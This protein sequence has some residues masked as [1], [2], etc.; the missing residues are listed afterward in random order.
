M[1]IPFF[2]KKLGLISYQKTGYTPTQS[3]QALVS[4]YEKTNGAAQEVLHSAIFRAVKQ[5]DAQEEKPAHSLIG[6]LSISDENKIISTLKKDG[7]ATL[8]LQLS[9][10][11]IN[12]VLNQIRN[13]R[14]RPEPEISNLI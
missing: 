9:T 6:K 7:Y 2:D 11:T 8:P 4:C 1:C 12:E 14:F 13:F 5:A 10:Q 3:H